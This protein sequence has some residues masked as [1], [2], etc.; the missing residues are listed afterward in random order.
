MILSP[1]RIDN[2]IYR[3]HNRNMNTTTAQNANHRTD[4]AWV[5]TSG[6]SFKVNGEHFTSEYR[7]IFTGQAIR[8]GWRMTGVDWYIFDAEENET[9]RAYSLTYAKYKAAE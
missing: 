2:R 9:G 4:L 7:N 6:K 1:L 3:V 5:K 8:K